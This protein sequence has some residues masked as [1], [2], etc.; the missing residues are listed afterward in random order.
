MARIGSTCKKIVEDKLSKNKIA[1][2]ERSI[3]TEQMNVVV[4]MNHLMGYPY[5]RKLVKSGE[6]NLMG[7]YY[8]IE[9]GEIY[10]YDKESKTFLR[11]E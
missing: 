10:N 7:W 2:E 6:L 1:P 3:Y 9:E 4:Q 8:D 5:I 11:V